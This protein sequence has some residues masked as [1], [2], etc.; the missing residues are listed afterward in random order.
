MPPAMTET[1]TLEDITGRL[2]RAAQRLRAGVL[3]TEAA[4]ALVEA[5]AQDAGRAAGELDRLF[6]VAAQDQPLAAHGQPSLL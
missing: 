5:C 3:D 1:E 6:R 4:A 2:E